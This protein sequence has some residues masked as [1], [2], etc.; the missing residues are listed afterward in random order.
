MPISSVVVYSYGQDTII[1]LME[2]VKPEKH[3]LKRL[4]GPAA[5][6]LEVSDAIAARS[7]DGY[8]G[9]LANG[10]NADLLPLAELRALDKTK[11]KSLQKVVKAADADTEADDQTHVSPLRTRL[12][13]HSSGKAIML[14]CAQSF[15][16]MHSQPFSAV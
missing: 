3:L 13:Q 7:D 8:G 1:S 10:L 9:E 12:L 16:A 6:L 4:T 2:A 5:S 11:I 15:S 14:R